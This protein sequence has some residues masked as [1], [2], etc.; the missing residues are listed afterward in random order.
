MAAMSIEIYEIHGTVV[1]I[2]SGENTLGSL[3]LTVNKGWIV[4]PIEL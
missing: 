2:G 3:K 4:R 1:P